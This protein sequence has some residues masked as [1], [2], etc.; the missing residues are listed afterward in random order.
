MTNTPGDLAAVAMQPT[1]NPD[2]PEI[3][4]AGTLP[5]LEPLRYAPTDV[6]EIAYYAAGPSMVTSCCCTGFP[7]CLRSP[8][9]A[10]RMATSRPPTAPPL[11][12]TSPDP[13]CTG[14]F[15]TPDTICRRKPRRLRR[16][17]PGPARPARQDV[18]VT[19]PA[20]ARLLS[21]NVGRSRPVTIGRHVVDTAIWKSAVEG[22]VN[23]RGVNLDGDDQ[24]DRSVHGGPDKAVYA[25]A[26]EEI[27]DWESELGRKLDTATFGENLTT[28][29]VDVSGAVVGERW[30]VGTTLLEVAQPR[31]PC[32]KLGIRLG[33]PG[34]VRRFAQASRP[35]AYLRIIEEGQL[36]AGDEVTVAHRPDHGVTMRLVF[37][38]I[39][40]DRELVPQALQAQQLPDDLREWMKRMGQRSPRPTG[41]DETPER[42]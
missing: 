28:E 24:A 14:R 12:I 18:Q 30:R 20:P 40:L 23:V 8:W 29:G 6:L 1:T 9:T 22:P 17:D 35:G 39:L 26:I 41:G 27:R 11:R 37:D 21:V 3:A 33:A 16:R 5:R 19:R 36:E 32:F 31:L 38:A 15:R 42:R 34:F 25:Y 13:V 7:R 10:W 4:S 2:L